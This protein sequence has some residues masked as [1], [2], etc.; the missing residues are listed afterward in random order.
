[1]N[2]S[3]KVDDRPILIGLF[4]QTSITATCNVFA[5]SGYVKYCLG[6]FRLLSPSA[7]NRAI[8]SASR[9]SPLSCGPL[10]GLHVDH[11]RLAVDRTLSFTV[12][13][14]IL[15][16]PENRGKRPAAN[17]PESVSVRFS[18]A[19]DRCLLSAVFL[20]LERGRSQHS[21]DRRIKEAS[22]GKQRCQE[23]LI[24]EMTHFALF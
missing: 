8:I 10:Q 19:K 18:P 1:M 16:W 15:S 23:S 4:I 6:R 12:W 11:A 20:Q 3:F 5:S 14:S 13:A 2:V 22:W 17:Q 9:S 21:I 24:W 7:T